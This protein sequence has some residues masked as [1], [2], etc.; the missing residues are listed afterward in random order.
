MT[1]KNV[2]KTSSIVERLA[3]LSTH[4]SDKILTQVLLLPIEE[5]VS[6][7]QV[8]T[9]FNEIEELAKTIKSDQQQ[10]PILVAPKN[11]EGKYVI[12]KGERRWRACK[13][14]GLDYIKAII[15]PKAYTSNEIIIGEL[16]ENIQREDLAP[17]EIANAIQRLLDGGLTRTEIQEKIG[18]SQSY[19]SMHISMVNEIPE[20][21]KDLLKAQ[22][23]LAAQTIVHLK[24]AFE[25]DAQAT[26]KACLEYK[27]NGV[28]RAEAKL[29]LDSILLKDKPIGNNDA[30][31]GDAGSPALNTNNDETATTLK[32]VPELDSQAEAVDSEF[33]NQAPEPAETPL[34]ENLP[35]SKGEG[36]LTAQEASVRNAE[37]AEAVKRPV[38]LAQVVVSR[39]IDG[40][41]QLGLL[42]LE[43]VSDSPDVVWV[44]CNGEEVLWETRH[45]MIEGVHEDS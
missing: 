38:T 33:N 16:V 25:L 14:L 37:Y 8:R 28:S 11:D 42:S 12:L 6:K 17:F 41:K 3:R 39:K 23:F 34:R 18:K 5:V 9:I 24:K 15:D 20:L 4:A 27:V 44:D 26:E 29:F 32:S 45:I 10:S 7:E 19:V 21:L 13:H 35:E 36:D 31:A 43:L 40:K 30:G 22:P 2:S 1:S